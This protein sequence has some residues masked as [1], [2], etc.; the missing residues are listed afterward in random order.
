MILEKDLKIKID[1]LINLGLYHQ[2]LSTIQT[3]LIKK[4]ASPSTNQ[5]YK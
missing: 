3:T 2:S 1:A 4:Q 5:H